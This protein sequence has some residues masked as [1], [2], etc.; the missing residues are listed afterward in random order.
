MSSKNISIKAKKIEVV[1]K[2]S[3]LKSVRDIQ[4]F[5]GFVNFYQQFIQDF[6]KIAAPLMSI[7]K[8]IMLLQVLTANEMLIANEVGGVKSDDKLI[9][10]YGKLLKGL[11][12]FKS[13]NLISKK[14]A[15]FKKPL[16]IRNSS[17]FD[18]KKTGP[19]FLTP[20]AKAIFNRLRLA[21]TKPLIL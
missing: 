20:K 6:S 10:K 9:E 21:F 17:N 14:L 2:Y 1:K 18:P 19:S 4:V 12:L 11:K 16:K 5:L 13:K 3:E 7:L 15:K 8:T